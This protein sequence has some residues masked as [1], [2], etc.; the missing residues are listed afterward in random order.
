MSEKD[1]GKIGA[2]EMKTTMLEETL[3]GV[4]KTRRKF[5]KDEMKLRVS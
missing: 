5:V 2:G 4:K 1:L 3:V